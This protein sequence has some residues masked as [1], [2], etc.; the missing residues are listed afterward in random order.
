V[1][2]IVYL[3]S[4]MKVTFLNSE[5]WVSVTPFFSRLWFSEF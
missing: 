5:L 4:V 2:K 3:L 1:F